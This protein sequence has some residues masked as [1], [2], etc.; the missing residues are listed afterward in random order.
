MQRDKSSALKAL[1]FIAA[2]DLR[3]HYPGGPSF[4]AAESPLSVLSLL[5]L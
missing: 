4:I 1:P 3:E 5:P 2:K